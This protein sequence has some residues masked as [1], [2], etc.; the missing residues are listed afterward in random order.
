MAKVYSLDGK[1]KGEV[2]ASLVFD[3]PYR[4]DIIQRAVVALSSSARQ[5]H[6]ADPEAGTKTSGDY[7]GSRR[8]T[9]RQTINKGNSRLPRVKTGGGGLGKVVRIPQAKGGRKAHPPVGK[10]YCKKINKK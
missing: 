8:N 7:Y 1:V 4:P 9:F 3:T 10:D 2:Q 5:R 6:A